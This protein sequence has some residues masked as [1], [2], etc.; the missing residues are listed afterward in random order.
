MPYS[1]TNSKGVTY[2]LHCNERTTKTGKVTRLF[3]FSRDIRPEKAVDE[4]PKGCRVEET[5]T[6]M[7]VVKKT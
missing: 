3:F 6:G 5:A 7:L 4:L 2:H 1:H